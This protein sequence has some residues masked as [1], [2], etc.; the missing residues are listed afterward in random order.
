MAFLH[1]TGFSIFLDFIYLEMIS[2]SPARRDSRI[3][4]LVARSCS[5]YNYDAVVRDA[6]VDVY[7]FTPKRLVSLCDWLLSSKLEFCFFRMAF[8]GYS[9]R[10]KK[11]SYFSSAKWRK[12][13]QQ[14]IYK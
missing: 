7:F 9:Q 11:I 1:R 10:R 8:R 14:W 5:R 12:R 6:G 2:S 4:P 3:K 13:P